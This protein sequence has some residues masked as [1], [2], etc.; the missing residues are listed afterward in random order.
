MQDKAYEAYPD[1]A[2]KVYDIGIIRNEGNITSGDAHLAVDYAT[3]LKY[4]LKHYK[5]KTEAKLAELNY[6]D[7]DD[8]KKSY[9]YKAI[10]IVIDAVGAFA[11][12][13]AAPHI[14]DD[15]QTQRTRP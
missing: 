2:K 12:R 6:A 9:F 8:L 3:V 1:H 4:G 11:A 7:V 10:L 5:D 14:P 13:Y 15:P